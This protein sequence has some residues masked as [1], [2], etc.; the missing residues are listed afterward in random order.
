MSILDRP[1]VAAAL[2]S[3]LA[4]ILAIEHDG[5]IIEA[6]AKRHDPLT[7]R[8][9]EVRLRAI[10]VESTDPAVR[11][12]FSP[13]SMSVRVAMRDGVAVLTLS[14]V[15]HRIDAVVIGALR[16]A[17]GSTSA[18]RRLAS[19]K[20]RI[21]EAA[22]L[23]LDPEVE[24]WVRKQATRDAARTAAEVVT[25]EDRQQAAADAIAAERHRVD[26]EAAQ[27]RR[28]AHI[29][30][31]IAG[32]DNDSWPSYIPKTA[33]NLRHEAIRRLEVPHVEQD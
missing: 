8:A 31:I 12:L 7:G 11:A 22:A 14:S 16:I 4:P 1:A 3:A 6:E 17:A 10:A 27:A 24:P 5:C 18:E 33:A 15:T 30:A 13:R 25:S 19:V 28:E 21:D 20:R 29:Q 9:V 23:A 26:I 2:A 32:L